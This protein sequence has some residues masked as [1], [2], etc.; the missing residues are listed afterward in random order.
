M[1]MKKV[2]S[3]LI[4][5]GH[6]ITY[7]VRKDGGIL[8]TSIDGKRYTAASGNAAARSMVGTTLSEARKSQIK[9]ITKERAKRR[10]TLEGKVAEEYKKVKAVWNKRFKAKKGEASGHGYLPRSKVRWVVENLG[11]EEALRRL[12]NMERYAQGLA[13]PENIQALADEIMRLGNLKKSSELKQLA[14]DLNAVKESNVIREA[15][16]YPAY[17][18]LYGVNHGEDPRTIANNIRIILG[19]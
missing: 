5:K 9:Y 3:E 18:M 8:I 19:L 6:K 2:V 1:T 7:Y 11:E 4:K 17:E 14:K 16:L 15:S 10:R 12:A 13:Y